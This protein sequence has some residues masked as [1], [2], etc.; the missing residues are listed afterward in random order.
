MSL[1]H[2]NVGKFQDYGIST[3]SSP[4][5]SVNHDVSQRP[6]CFPWTDDWSFILS[7]H[8]DVV[9][10]EFRVPHSCWS[11]VGKFRCV[12]SQMPLISGK[13]SCH[14]IF[15]IFLNKIWLPI[16]GK[17]PDTA[18]FWDKFIEFLSI[19]PFKGTLLNYSVPR[20]VAITVV[21]GSS[22]TKENQMFSWYNTLRK[23]F[24]CT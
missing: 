2:R 6:G 11:N 10:E 4:Q 5:P 16:I 9:L 18:N 8:C 20:Y 3:N 7:R 22:K 14:V 23:Y 17:S 15:L 12:L 19:F 1:K 13:V 24:R 21:Y